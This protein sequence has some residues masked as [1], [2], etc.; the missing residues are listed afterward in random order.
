MDRPVATSGS[1]APAAANEL[2]L[3]GSTSEGPLLDVS[4]LSIGLPTGRGA[5]HALRDVSFSLEP[6]EAVGVVGESGSGKTMLVRTVM[7]LTPRGAQVEGVI[8]FQ[9]VDVA[10]LEAKERQ[11]LWGREVSMVFQD[12][13]TSLN[14]TRRIGAQI[15]DPLRKH[16]G[17]T[18]TQAIAKA[19]ELLDHV[20]IPD[21]A[22][23]LRQY[24]HEL[25]GG[26]RQRVMIAIAVS[27]HP[28]LLLADE[29]TT[30][31][32]VTVQSQILRLLAD[33]RQQLGMTLVLIS[34]DLGVVAGVT[35][36]VM[37]MYGGRIVE[38]A[39]VDRLFAHPKHP[40]TVGLLGAIPRLGQDRGA[41]LRPIAGRPPDLTVVEDGC[42][43]ADRCD[44]V[45]DTCRRVTPPLD[46][47][48]PAHWAAC[49][50]PVTV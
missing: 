14:P 50:N 28:K 23:R 30:A 2:G 13:M 38:A 35:D 26:M 11:R 21:A 22:K 45:L 12:P 49:F 10:A 8:R 19:V 17:L 44:R 33:L 31:L 15:T 5:V 47:G 46:E 16:L 4:H 20:R 41:R 42:A 27:C 36:R 7:G 48:E 25:S 43:F 3:A 40:Y 1:G 9:G 34:H 24:P 6:G 37:V 39:P 32:D 29:P 18:R